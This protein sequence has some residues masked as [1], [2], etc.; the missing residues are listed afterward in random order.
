MFPAKNGQ[1]SG[2]LPEKFTIIATAIEIFFRPL[3]IKGPRLL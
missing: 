1:G 3:R 2:V